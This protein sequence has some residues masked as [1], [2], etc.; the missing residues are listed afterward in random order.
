MRKAFTLNN[1]P[2]IHLIL[3]IAEV[4]AAFQ[5]E[6]KGQHHVLLDSVIQQLWDAFDYLSTY[7]LYMPF[8]QSS[9][10]GKSRLLDE[11]A[12]RRFTIAMNLRDSPPDSFGKCR[13]AVRHGKHTSLTAKSTAY[14][15]PDASLQAFFANNFSQKPFTDCKYRIAAYFVALFSVSL[16]KMKDFTSKK[17]SRKYLAADWRSKYMDPNQDSKGHAGRQSF[18]GEVVAMVPASPFPH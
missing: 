13:K 9:G 6:F 17:H 4:I 10:M 11:V 3:Q 18:Y 15:P 5:S 12:K 14:P 1:P 16:E 7:G 8:L 2:L